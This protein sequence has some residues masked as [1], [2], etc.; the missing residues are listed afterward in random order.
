[1]GSY[2]TADKSRLTILL[3]CRLVIQKRP[4][5]F[6][7]RFYINWIARNFLI[8]SGSFVFLY[9]SLVGDSTHSRLVTYLYSISV[10]GFRL[11]VNMF[12]SKSF[13]DI[14]DTIIEIRFQ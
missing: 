7:S 11:L 5:E 6:T 13:F 9:S 12:T 1:M 2:P 3:H 14:L 8:K 10:F 4:N